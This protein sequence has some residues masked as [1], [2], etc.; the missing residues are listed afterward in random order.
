M[1]RKGTMAKAQ[2]QMKWVPA[3]EKNRLKGM[4]QEWAEER[5]IATQMNA[6]R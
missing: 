1:K 3:V 4:K 6:T 2:C 5:A